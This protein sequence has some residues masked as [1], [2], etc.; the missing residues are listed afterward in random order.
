MEEVSIRIFTL[1][2]Y[3]DDMRP[4]IAAHCY[5]PRVKRHRPRVALIHLPYYIIPKY[6]KFMKIN[7]IEL[8]FKLICYKLYLHN[9]IFNILMYN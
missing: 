2:S 8:K 6:K 9:Y 5:R 7:L 3:Y 1:F 4:I